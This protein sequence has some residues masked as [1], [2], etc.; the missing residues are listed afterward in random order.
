MNLNA[1]EA[2]AAVLALIFCIVL[3]LRSIELR[4]ARRERQF[5]LL[6]NHLGIDREWIPPPT[7]KVKLLAR[8]LTQ[9][10]AAIKAYREQTGLG[11]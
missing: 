7:D 10:I 11:A 1:F 5:D 6:M 2:L 4:T 3:P 8:D 9:K